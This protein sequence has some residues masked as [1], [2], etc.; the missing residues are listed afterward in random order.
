MKRAGRGHPRRS[1]VSERPL[2]QVVVEVLLVLPIFLWLVFSIME[3]GHLA[4]RAIVLHHAAYEV[5]RY[6]SLSA[7]GTF[8][9]SLSDCG[10]EPNPDRAAMRSVAEKILPK[11]RAM[12]V[13][14]SPPRPDRQSG[15]T[16]FDLIVTLKQDVPMIFPMT[17]VWLADKGSRTR[18]MAASVPMPVEKPLYK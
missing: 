9:P 12:E 4:F 10:S 5:A 1:F 6:G 7:G 11:L 16:N 13:T 3:I 2:G 14:M 15:C 18:L 8:I 17:G